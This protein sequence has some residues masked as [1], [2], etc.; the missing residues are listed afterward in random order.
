MTKKIAV[1]VGSGSQTSISQIV[2]HHLAKVAPAGLTFNFVQIA[3]LSLYDRD[4]D[5]QEIAS[6]QRFRAEIAAS[7]AVLLI[8]PEH[9][10]SFSAMIKNA[11]DIGSRP[12]GQS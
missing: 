3:D 5:N 6:Y 1:L 7:D 10:A 9:N 11:I 8:T 12:M 2:A 4:S